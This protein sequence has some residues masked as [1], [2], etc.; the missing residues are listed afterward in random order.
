MDEG[1]DFNS[2]AVYQLTPS[3]WEH[4]SRRKRGAAYGGLFSLAEPEDPLIT[5]RPHTTR[6]RRHARQAPSD[7]QTAPPTEP[8]R[9]DEEVWTLYGL[10]QLSSH[11]VCNDGTT[12][13]PNICG[14]DCSREFQFQ[15]VLNSQCTDSTDVSCSSLA[16]YAPIMCVFTAQTINRNYSSLSFSTFSTCIFA[17][18]QQTCFLSRIG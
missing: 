18:N 15:F 10:F 16:T 17:S 3:V 13:S 1:A 9:Q 11:L 12:P 2:S 14:M 7:T 6:E 8:P 4:Q 5:I